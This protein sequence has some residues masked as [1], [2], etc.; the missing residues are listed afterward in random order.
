MP[1]YLYKARDAA[2]KLVEGTLVA[3]D[4]GSLV[5][6]LKEQD[7]YLTKFQESKKVKIKAEKKKKTEA[8]KKESGIT[9][10]E[11]VT[12]KDVI[13]FTNYLATIFSAGIPLLLGLQD[14]EDMTDKLKFK[15]II[16]KIRRDVE[17]GASIS[18]PLAE[19]PAVFSE[20]YVSLVKVGETS[21]SMDIVLEE[22]AMFL[23]WEDDLMGELKKATAYPIFLLT[24][25]GGM[26]GVLF[27][28]AFPKI[29][30]V[31]DTLDVEMPLITK[32][33][34]GL[35]DFIS[36]KWY[37]VLLGIVVVIF[38]PKMIRKFR[39][40]QL[41]M[42]HIKLKIPVVGPLIIKVNI[43]H[44]VRHLA[45][46]W[47]AGLNFSTSLDY[48]KD[49]VGNKVIGN[50]IGKAK[51]GVMEGGQL[52]DELR[53][54]KLF[55]SLVLRMIAIGETSGEMDKSLEKIAQYYGK[56]IPVTVKKFLSLLEPA[57]IGL[58]A[59]IVLGVAMAI[60][61]PIYSSIGAIGR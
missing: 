53:K 22:L 16:R 10:F 7:L 26:L 23:E 47:K 35:T 60:Y 38:T 2:G 18:E 25:V 49:A 4:E 57:L 43:S 54:F 6:A 24:A 32:I 61:L 9:I 39:N 34:I 41:F 15:R 8:E 48:V 20:T 33:V 5:S 27:V 12:R 44:F 50:I 31:L 52:S 1:N 56:E 36:K 28:F 58:L 11:R 30:K 55:P 21:G 46:M 17:G 42:D 19:Y 51:E 14:L 37:V 13:G 3:E 40:G 29:I 59:I 45:L